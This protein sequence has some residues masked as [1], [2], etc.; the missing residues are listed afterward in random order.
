MRVASWLVLCVLCVPLHA[1]ELPDQLEEYFGYCHE[2]GMFNGVVL[3]KQG[4]EVVYEQALGLADFSDSRPLDLDTAFYLASVSK[5]F[6]CMAAMILA[7]QGKLSLEAPLTDY[8]PEFT[9]FGDDVRVTHLMTHTSGIP[10]HYTLLQDAPAGLDNERVVEILLEHGALDF[11]PG[12]EYSYS[13]GAY[14]LLSMIIGR[15]AEQDFPVVMN[16]L[17]FEPL[18]MTRTQVVHG[19]PP[20]ITNRALG[21]AGDGS[22]DDYQLL[23]TGAGGMY[24]TVGDLSRWDDALAA[25][26][27]VSEE[28]MERAYTRAVLA[29]GSATSYGFGWIIVGDGQRVWH[30]GGLAGFATVLFRDRGKGDTLIMLSNQGSATPGM[31]TL[32]EAVGA[33]LAGG[34][35]RLPAIPVA[36]ELREIIDSEGVEAALARYETIRAEEADR[37]DLSEEQLNALG[38][39]YAGAGDLEVAAALLARN[40]EAHPEA[41]NT[42]DSLGE[43][44]LMQGL[45]AESLAS[46]TRSYELNPAN[47]HA[48]RMIE[49]LKGD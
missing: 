32:V 37:F 35:A 5:Q 7:E 2:N 16:E 45:R 34:R 4:G 22:L 14:V 44:Q 3:V 49:E 42:W 40:C 28:M 21:Y 33:M 27:L 12:T 47:A 10:D 11:A 29:D 41:F 26:T 18:G 30:S 23:T 38:Y 15:A 9:G 36:A 31:Q 20:E 6:T 8:F 1:S 24:T 25:G 43:I 48:G 19:S 13:N 46:Y 39:E 17:I